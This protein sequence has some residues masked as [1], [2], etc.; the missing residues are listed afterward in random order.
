MQDKSLLRI[1]WCEL[2]Q[3]K[4]LLVWCGSTKK[5]LRTDTQGNQKIPHKQQS[6]HLYVF[7]FKVFTGL[8]S[9]STDTITHSMGSSCNPLIWLMLSVCSPLQ[10][11]LSTENYEIWE[12]A[13]Q[14]AEAQSNYVTH[15]KFYRNKREIHKFNWFWL[16]ILSLGLKTC[17]MRIS[18]KKQKQPLPWH[19]IIFL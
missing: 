14:K 17:P 1:F 3:Q 15:L 2:A 10:Q 18:I 6:H 8:S 4:G 19:F 9:N 11:L 7:K 16:L 5:V 12:E 13:D